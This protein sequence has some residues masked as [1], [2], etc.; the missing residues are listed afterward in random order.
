MKVVFRVDASIWIGS[1]H[2]M[3]CLVLAKELE[4]RLF[5]VTFACLPQKGDLISFIKQRGFDV[6]EL[7]EADVPL[8][9][10]H[11]ADYRAWLQRSVTEDVSDFLAHISD[12]DLVITDHYAIDTGWQTQVKNRL[13]C[14]LVAIDDL[15]RTHDAD[16]IIDQ[17][18]GRLPDEY[19]SQGIVLSGVDYALLNPL[20]SQ[21]RSKAFKKVVNGKN[22]KVLI[23]MGGVDAPNATLAV[24]K[25]IEPLT[26]VHVTVLLGKNA[27]N[28]QVVSDFCVE[29]SHI[30]HLEFV[31][32][33]AS[34]MLEHDLAIGAPGTTSWERACMGLPSIVV[35]I[36]DN[37]LT[38]AEALEKNNVSLQVA[39]DKLNTHLLDSMFCLIDKAERLQE[40]G[41][42]IC[43][44]LGVYRVVSVIEKNILGKGCIH[45]V[46]ASQNDIRRVFD[47]Q[48][49]AETRKYALNQNAPSW[50]EHLSWMNNKLASTT[51]FFYMIKSLSTEEKLG[52]VRLDHQTDDH[53]LVSIFIDPCYFGQGIA[54]SALKMLDAIHPMFYLH[55]TVLKENF[56]SQ[57]L[58]EKANYQRLSEET[59]IRKP[60]LELSE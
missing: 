12:A 47:W 17:T 14:K 4:R 55:A 10:T 20:F 15:V 41:L 37:Q 43:D 5:E 50:Q 49:L 38:I 52:V 45:L 36:A 3:R 16:L 31:E 26:N 27:P 57:R 28:F 48:S 51:D 11:S 60:I 53:Y 32:D 23:S 2:V 39:L 59:F 58:F 46:K 33:M 1:G 9:P 13:G 40:A 30:Q 54:L 18:L 44:G 35:P 25:A 29:R 19:H 21:R 56:A 6:I 42:N 34:L 7:T 8:R 24:L 22:P